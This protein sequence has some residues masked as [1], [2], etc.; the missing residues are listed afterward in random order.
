MQTLKQRFQAEGTKNINAPKPGLRK[1][2][3]GIGGR[4]SERR[5]QKMGWG[6][7]RETAGGQ[8]TEMLEG[9]NW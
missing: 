8:V 1:T 2:E 4:E 5:V 6:A 3:V 7:W 9:L